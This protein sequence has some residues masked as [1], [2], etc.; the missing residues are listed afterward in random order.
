MGRHDWARAEAIF[1]SVIPIYIETQSANNINT[2]IARIKLGRTL[3]RQK[4]YAEAEAQTRA[5]YNTLVSQMDPKVTWL[6]SARQDLLEEYTALN[7]ADQAAKFRAEAAA[8]DAHPVQ[9]ANKK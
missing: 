4:R 7:Q 6:K 2:G 5:G 3:V 1:R 8:L 9:V